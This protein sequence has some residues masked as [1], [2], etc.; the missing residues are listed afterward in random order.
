[1][2]GFSENSINVRTIMS[3][4]TSRFLN[5]SFC[6]NVFGT[7]YFLSCRDFLSVAF[8]LD[9]VFSPQEVKLLK[10]HGSSVSGWLHSVMS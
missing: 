7:S 6:F 2:A 10:S 3:F 1:M 4:W 9:H 8:V 5:I